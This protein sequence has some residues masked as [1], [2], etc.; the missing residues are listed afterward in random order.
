MDLAACKPFSKLKRNDLEQ[1]PI[2][3][4]IHNDAASS[5]GELTDE[6]FVEP[7]QFKQIPMAEFG[8]FIVAAEIQLKAGEPM[9]G[10][11]EI[12]VA[13][14]KV[15]VTPVIQFLLDRQ[16]QIPAVETNRLLSRYTQKLE[17]FPTGWVLK[18]LVEGESELRSGSIKGGDMKDL[19]AIGLD[20]LASL[21]S[22]RNS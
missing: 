8:Q 4:W 21:K 16:L 2:W 9:P 1:S 17:N 7:T 22:L 15:G 14:G 11:C 5:D 13:N 19:R 12:T 10:I 18:V 20:I 3:Q 6:S